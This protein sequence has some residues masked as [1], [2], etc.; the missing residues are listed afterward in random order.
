[1]SRPELGQREV[2]P[3]ESELA[4]A[5]WMPLQEYADLQFL[6][7]RPLHSAVLDRCVAYAQ[8]RYA[9]LQGFKLAGGL[10]HEPELLLAGD[11]APA[12]DPEN[13]SRL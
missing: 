13:S 7:Q 6:Q 11:P 3:Q 8:G 5:K 2:V 9:G 12:A 1:M 10:R 4:A